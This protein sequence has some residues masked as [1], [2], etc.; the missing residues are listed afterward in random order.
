MAKN[1][2]LESEEGSSG[3]YYSF[4]VIAIVV[5]SVAFTMLLTAVGETANLADKDWY[6][7]LSFS[8]SPIAII[9]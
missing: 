4:L 1:P 6:I 5:F 8:V 2:L 9:A 3:L 7:F